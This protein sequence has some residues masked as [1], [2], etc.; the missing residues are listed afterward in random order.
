MKTTVLF[1][2][3]NLLGKPLHIC[4]MTTIP[5]AGDNVALPGFAG[6]IKNVNWEIKETECFVSIIVLP[7]STLDT[8]Q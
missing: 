7:H 4:E 3:Y 8:T 1:F 6:Y 2:E 5:R